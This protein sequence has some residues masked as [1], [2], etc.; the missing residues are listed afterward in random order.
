MLLFGQPDLA[1]HGQV[2]SNAYNA[3]GSD[4]SRR[5]CRWYANRRE[6][7]VAAHVKSLQRCLVARQRLSLANI[8]PRSVRA[9]G[10]PKKTLVSQG[11]SYLYRTF[12]GSLSRIWNILFNGAPQKVSS[13]LFLLFVFFGISVHAFPPRIC[14]NIINDEKEE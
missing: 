7:I 6:R 5:S 10:P 12:D 2:L 8:N 13:L 4:G 14:N 9:F 1:Q 11:R 3:V